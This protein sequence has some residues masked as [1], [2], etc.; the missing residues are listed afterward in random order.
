IG[1]ARYNVGLS[2]IVFTPHHPPLGLSCPLPE[3]KRP[4]HSC[5]S[6]TCPRTLATTPTTSPQRLPRRPAAARH[7]RC[8]PANVVGSCQRVAAVA[9][10]ACA[11]GNPAAPPAP[12]SSADDATSRRRPQ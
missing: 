5:S 10:Q 1:P 6:P 12:A 4:S 2:L 3:P 9:H 11:S 8:V 7:C